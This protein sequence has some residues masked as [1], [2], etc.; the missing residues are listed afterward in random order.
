[1]DCMNNQTQPWFGAARRVSKRGADCC[2]LAVDEN[3][4][5]LGPDFPLVRK[6]LRGYE[7]AAVEDLSCLRE[8][9]P[10]GADDTQRL[11]RH[12][13]SIAKALSAGDLARAHILGLYFP[14][15]RLTPDQLDRL[16]KAFALLKGNF[17]PDEPRDE[18]GRWT[19]GSA[20]AAPSS[21]RAFT[22]GAASVG[23]GT[24]RPAAT[25]PNLMRVQEIVPFDPEVLPDPLIEG[26]PLPEEPFPPYSLLPK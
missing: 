15:N 14:I 19:T 22:P 13:E 7:P 17:N 26:E 18:R 16:R 24:S 11:A 12:L 10:L 5:T 8:V 2:G 20:T 23:A 6:T 4:V 25:H 9:V 21:A 1:M 3:G